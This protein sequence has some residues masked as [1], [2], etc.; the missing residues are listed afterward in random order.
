MEI[1]PSTSKSSATIIKE[2]FGLRECSVVL[3]DI[4][5]NKS[6]MNNKSYENMEVESSPSPSQV[7]LKLFF[8][9]INSTF[10]FFYVYFFL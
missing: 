8:L 5:R 1:Q 6:A 9:L 4:S 3:V 2:K 7:H 10:L